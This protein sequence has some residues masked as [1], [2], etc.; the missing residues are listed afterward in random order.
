MIEKKLKYCQYLQQFPD[1]PHATF[2]EIDRQIFR[3]THNPIAENDFLPINLI[4]P[5]PR[6]LDGSDKMCMAYGLSMFDTLD[7][8]LTKYKKLY[9]KSRDLQKEQFKQDKGDHVVSLRVTPADG[10][11]D[12]PNEYGH[13]T[14]HE[15]SET[16]FEQREKTLTRIFDD[17]EGFSF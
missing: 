5:P 8:S 2:R 4:K 11:A 6:W 15:Y 3:W 16:H 14:F 10:I 12:E 1:C 13:F 7:H 17:N 9:L